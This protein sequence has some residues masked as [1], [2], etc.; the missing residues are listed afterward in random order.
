M[1]ITYRFN[2]KE[3][4]RGN[5]STQFVVILILQKG[6]YVPCVFNQFTL[7]SHVFYL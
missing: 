7:A 1:K 3:I 5:D 4:H 6:E 2:S